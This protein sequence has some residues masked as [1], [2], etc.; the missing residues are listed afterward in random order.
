MAPEMLDAES[1]IRDIPV[2]AKPET[3]VSK[4]QYGSGSDSGFHKSSR[5]LDLPVPG[6]V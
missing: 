5:I 6:S 3:V 4:F 1:P 2:T